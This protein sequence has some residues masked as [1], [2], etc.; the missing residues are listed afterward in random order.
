MIGYPLRSPNYDFPFYT[1]QHRWANS[2]NSIRDYVRCPERTL[3]EL[4]SASDKAIL[5][6][7]SYNFLFSI[8]RRTSHSINIRQ[9][10]IVIQKRHFTSGRQQKHSTANAIMHALH[11]TPWAYARRAYSC[12]HYTSRRIHATHIDMGARNNRF[13]AFI[14]N[15]LFLISQMAF[16]NTFY[17]RVNDVRRLSHRR[18]NDGCGNHTKCIQRE[19][20]TVRW[21]SRWWG[22][23]R[24]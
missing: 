4:Q 22:E 21:T 2:C 11:W 12:T 18:K 1:S 3:L 6:R 9:T 20:T 14:A 10:C 13:A 5:G 19:T 15:T 16:P 23:G 17:Q 7:P 24:A 8:Q